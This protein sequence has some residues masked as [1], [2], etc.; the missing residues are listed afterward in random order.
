MNLI[1]LLAALAA[2]AWSLRLPA[3]RER[4]PLAAAAGAAARLPWP[5]DPTARAVLLVLPLPLAVG[6]AQWLLAGLLGGL[7]SL[8]LA[9]LVLALALG[10]GP[11]W[12]EV[13][14]WLAARA[15]GDEAGAAEAAAA[16]GRDLPQATVADTILVEAVRRLFAPLLWFLVLGPVGAALYRCAWWLALRAPDGTAGAEVREAARRLLW[17]LDWLPARGTALAYALA[18]SFDETLAGWR[19]FARRSADP[20]RGATEELLVCTGR[21]ALGL[22]GDDGEVTADPSAEAV[23]RARDLVRRAVV[24]WVT[25]VALLTLGG[26]IA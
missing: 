13:D 2:D 7:A 19:C 8:L 24:V 14:G 1:A 21:G 26:W 16:L 5:A 10:P 17:L 6:L 9:A 15:C 22:V 3:W 11:L 25:A 23:R 4:V 18:G 12:R 20:G